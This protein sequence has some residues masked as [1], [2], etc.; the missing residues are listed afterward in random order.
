MPLTCEPSFSVGATDRIEDHTAFPVPHQ[1][2]CN[3]SHA[4]LP[5]ALLLNFCGRLNPMYSACLGQD[6]SSTFN[7][8]G[9]GCCARFHRSV[10]LHM[11]GPITIL[12]RSNA[13][14][15]TVAGDSSGEAVVYLACYYPLRSLH[16]TC[17]RSIICDACAGMAVGESDTGDGHSG[18]SLEGQTRTFGTHSDPDGS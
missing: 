4:L 14:H 9:L 2:S 15:C 7:F 6:N 18:G 5:P 8:G 10:Q 12:G 16:R 3:Y 17:M 1:H 13:A 11:A